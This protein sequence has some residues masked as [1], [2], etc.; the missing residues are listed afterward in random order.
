MVNTPKARVALLSPV[1]SPSCDG[2]RGLGNEPHQMMLLKTRQMW[3][4][5][6]L[7][8]AGR[9]EVDK[10]RLDLVSDEKTL[11][12]VAEIRID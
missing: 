6:E 2:E 1:S 11:A 7:S 3:T 4:L 12:T 10:V 8:A 9:Q 5:G